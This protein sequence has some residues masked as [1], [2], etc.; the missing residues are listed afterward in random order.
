LAA[1][2]LAE[3]GL[4]VDHNTLWRWLREAGLWTRQRARSPY[5]QRREQREHFGAL[6]Q[7]D[8]SHHCWFEER[9]ERA[10]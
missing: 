10:A 1:E 9:G 4:E 3:E 5:R 8:G 6:V 2:K 7:L